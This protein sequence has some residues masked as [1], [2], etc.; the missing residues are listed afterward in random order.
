MIN[1]FYN[2]TSKD[3]NL[4]FY[5]DVLTGIRKDYYLTKDKQKGKITQNSSSES[6]FYEFCLESDRPLK[7]RVSDN[8]HIFSD[9]KNL[10]DGKYCVSYYTTLGLVKQITF[11]RFHTLLKV[12]YFNMTKSTSPYFI[13]EPRKSSNG[14]CLLINEVGS[15]KSIV[16]VPM[17]DIDDEY[18]FDK[19]EAEFN[20]YSAIA[21]TNEGVVK[22]LDSK[23][24]EEFEKFVDRAQALK[25]TDTAPQSFIE[26]DDAVLAKKLNPKDFNVKRNLSEIVNIADAEEFSFDNEDDFEI[27]EE[28]QG[29]VEFTAEDYLENTEELALTADEDVCCDTTD[30]SDSYFDEADIVEETVDEPAEV[31]TEITVDEFI[32]A[33]VEEAVA[34]ILI[35]DGI[36]EEV[37]ENELYEE[38]IEEPS[39]QVEIV[40]DASA[41]ISVV[42]FS[43]EFV[44][45]EN[46]EPD[47][48][49]ENS[50]T[51]YLYYGQLDDDNKRTGFGRTTTDDGKTAYEGYY[52]NNKRDGIGA[53]Y[54]KNGELCYYGNWK[55]NKRDGFGIGVSSFDKSVHI[56]KFNENKPYGDGV[57]V[58]N[59]GEIRFVRRVLSNGF[60]VEFSFEGDKII[61]KKYNSDGEIIS[62]NTSNL[63]YF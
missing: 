30:I 3:E 37:S 33:P 58:D 18:I 40:E 26:E 53:Y 61:V 38:V 57:R 35:E 20:D 43:D 14:L 15:F 17:P 11:S 29:F 28:Q 1:C 51:R 9:S 59:D 46:I 48:V 7:W 23:Q 8:T 56:G 63:F 12:E 39:L 21:S 4:N 50:N 55:D 62:E 25:L 13:I 32:E 47:I 2:I 36:I 45:G 10:D 42:E 41:D 16:L 19:V 52:E 34:D 5:T 22:F 24:L 49:I 6:I 44:V 60:S 54:Y 31:F 27:K